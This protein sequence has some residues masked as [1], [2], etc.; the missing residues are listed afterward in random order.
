MLK[1]MHLALFFVEE[2]YIAI[3]SFTKQST[4]LVFWGGCLTTLAEGLTGSALSE[5]LDLHT[6]TSQMRRRA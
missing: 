6:E 1:G 2:F 4:L 3:C 5:P